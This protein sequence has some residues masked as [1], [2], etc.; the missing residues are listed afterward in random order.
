MAAQSFQLI[1]RT[2]PIPGKVF[3][4]GNNEL[5]IGRDISNDIVI[6]DV[7][8]SRKHARLIM[9]PGGYILEDL[10]ST[11]GTFVNGQ[12]LVSPRVLRGG[13]TIM[14]GENVSLVFESA[15]DADATVVSVPAFE[16]APATA[17]TPPQPVVDKSVA[18]QAGDQSSPQV[19]A[20]QVP[21]GPVD[22][23]DYA[24]FTPEEKPAKKRW[25]WIGCG[26][27]V[28]LCI[29]TAIGAYAFDTLNLYC[30]PPFNILFYCP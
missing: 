21:A 7:E 29:V 23:Q 3:D 15:Y 6:S 27:L 22:L 10:G 9:E 5:T 25:V 26:C 12:R 30:T 24:D 14:L 13:E 2:G 28:L 8:V 17:Y 16:P 1:M 19:Y 20:G 4:L 11:N 18:R